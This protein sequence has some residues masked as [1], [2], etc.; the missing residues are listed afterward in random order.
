VIASDRGILHPPEPGVLPLCAPAGGDSALASNG[1]TRPG[2]AAI[3]LPGRRTPR[4]DAHEESG[5]M[6]VTRRRTYPMSRG[7]RAWRLLLA[8]FAVAAAP[9]VARAA[10]PMMRACDDPCLAA[11]RDSYRQCT[12]SATG[13]FQD[14]VGGCLAREHDCVEA[15]RTQ[16]QECLDST[17]SDAELERCDMDFETETAR[18]R[19]TFPLVPKRSRMLRARCISRAE[20]ADFRCRNG[21]R[22]RFRRAVLTCQHGFTACTGGCGAGGPPGGSGACRAQGRAEFRSVLA[23]CKLTFQVTSS[24]C[25]NRD[26]TC[27]QDCGDARATCEAPTQA[28][29]QAALATCAATSAAAIAACQATN[30]VGTPLFQQCVTDAQATAAECGDAALAAAAPGLAACVEPFVSCVHACPPPGEAS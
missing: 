28:A 20:T 26:V 22:R 16:R 7:G 4:E 15:C 14:A 17:G 2:E 24:G 9:A 30:P 25:I 18:C 1:K 10:M 6:I 27:V 23:N 11:A 13:A 5:D 21:V 3:N 29:L 8:G 12:S 19:D